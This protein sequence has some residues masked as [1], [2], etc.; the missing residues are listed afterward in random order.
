M[1]AA[2]VLPR[3]GYGAVCAATYALS[4][5][6]EDTLRVR[7]ELISV[8]H[9]QVF[10]AAARASRAL[11][12]PWT[13]PPSTSAA[14]RRYLKARSNDRNIGLLV[15]SRSDDLVGYVGVSEIVR[16]S[17]QSG[18]LGYYVF[19]PFQRR[20]FMSA[21]LGQVVTRLF[22]KHGLHRVEAN[23]QPSN[24]DSIQLVRRLGF[25]KEGI[26]RRYL[27]IKGKWMDHERWAVTRE[28]WKAGR[29]N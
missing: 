10:L 3:H 5:T 25:R 23:I 9:E 11:H 20:G 6:Q 27:K 15:F 12:E 16:G 26:S 22:R 29:A 1:R 18:Y 14:F 28:E 7:L 21:A 13:S 19:A 4:P 2:P 24:T 17:F 8:K